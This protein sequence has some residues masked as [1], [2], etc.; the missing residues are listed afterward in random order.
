MKERNKYLFTSKRLGFRNWDINDIDKMHEIN[1]DERVMQ[2]FPSL[3]SKE[4]TAEF[5]ARMMHQFQNKGFCY[6]AVDKLENNEFIGF[7]GLAEQTYQADFTPCVDIGWRIKSS[8]WNK[9]FATEG[10]KRCLDYAINDLKLENIFS[11]APKVNVKSEHI[12]V[13]IG[14]IKQYEFEH[15][16]LTNN[17]QLRTCVLYKTT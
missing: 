7:I 13:K 5:I 12:M 16:L 4:Q 3:P 17:D 8:E 15:S 1:S 9:G 6:F 2:F 11:I 10:A 14:L